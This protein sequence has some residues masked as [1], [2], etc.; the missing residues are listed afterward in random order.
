MK[1][2][3]ALLLVLSMVLSLSITSAF[4]DDAVTGTGTAQGRSGP[5]TVKLSFDGDTIT[6]VEIV[7]SHETVGVSDAAQEIIPARIVEYQTTSLDAVSGAT[8]TSAAL[9]LAAEA[10]IKDA[11]KDPSNYKEKVPTHEAVDL[12][13][14]DCDIVVVGGGIAGLMSAITAKAEGA[15]DVILIEKHAEIGGSAALSSAFMVTAEYDKF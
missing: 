8:L 6:D 10:A 12:E 13:D 4:A 9:R 11:G 1:K 7:E 3:L 15:G 14:M 2:V 5:V